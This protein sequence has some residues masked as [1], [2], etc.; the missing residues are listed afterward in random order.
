MKHSF[1]NTDNIQARVLLY[2][3]RSLSDNVHFRLALYEFEDIIS[4]VD[5][6]DLL[7]PERKR[8][9]GYGIRIAN[10]LA[11][12]Y[13]TSINPGISKSKVQ[14]N[15]DLFFAVVYFPSD[16]LHIKYVEGWKDCCRTS[17]CWLNEIWA[18]DIIDDKYF[19]KILAEFD[20]VLIPLAGSINSVQQMINKKCFYL[21][22]GVDAPLFCPYPIPPRR[23][24]DVYSIGR[25]SKETHRAILR[26]VKENKIFYIYDTIDGEH[27][28]N[29]NEHRIL[30]ANVAKRSRYFI[31]NP[32]KRDDP[33]ETGGQIEFGNRFFEGAASGTI[34]IGERP[35]NE[36]FKKVFD[37]PDAVIHLPFGSDKIGEIINE[38][39]SHP[40]R[41]E[42]IRRDNVAQ[43]LLRHDWVYRWE[44]VLK[45]AGLDPMPQLLER[46]KGLIK[47][48][49]IVKNAA[50][51]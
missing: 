28:I 12:S 26:M 6:V 48:S 10:R 30:Y 39:D 47:L 34:M 37:W 7:T 13:N 41:Q 45:I 2:S 27:V 49:S 11:T 40:D 51:L 20:Y 4:L 19:L 38:L 3:Q 17:I 42:N 8:R 33:G 22:H 46:K 36:Q 5:S 16:L 1:G 50:S 44:A 23:V 25:R 9:Y 14:K 18:R 24:I 15:Y 21:P 43:S 32:G 35:K 31:V 29:P